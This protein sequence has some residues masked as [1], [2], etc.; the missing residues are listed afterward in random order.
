[1]SSLVS[2]LIPCFNSERWIA[3][4]IESALAQTWPKTEI[5]VVDDGSTDGSLDV[6]RQF[7]GR[8]RWATGQNQG[9]PAARNKLLEMA[10]GDW[11]QYLD[12]DDYLLPEKISSQ[13]LFLALHS[14][15]DLV[16]GPITVERWS[17]QGSLQELL[18]IPEPHD[19]WVLLARWYLPQ[20]GACL[21][22]KK[23]ISDV[24]GWRLGQPCCQEHELYL[25]LLIAEKRFVHCESNGA[26]YRQWSGGSVCTRDIHEVH[27]R[28][29]EI[30]QRAEQCLHQTGQLTTERLRAIN[31]AR[32]EVARS[33]MQYNADLASN[34]VAQIHDVDPKFVPWGQAARLPYRL[35]YGF[36]GFKAAE[37]IA[38]AMRRYR[39]PRLLQQ[40][41]ASMPTE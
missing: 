41:T 30:E 33:I 6:I 12:A 2:I 1:M 18:A 35:V 10:R 23:A 13:M 15:A 40:P 28:R 19:P 37:G 8:I 20:T 21:W 29:L 4:T 34:I 11:V 26:V 9:A 32:F 17:E 22:R 39:R 36:F 7:E 5:I 24:G 27:R 31:Q 14:D 38:A 3:Q 16:Y 25:R